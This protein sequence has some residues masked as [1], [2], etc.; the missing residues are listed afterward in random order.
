ME[1]IGYTTSDF[2]GRYRHCVEHADYD[3]ARA[4][5]DA[6]E[7]DEIGWVWEDGSVTFDGIPPEPQRG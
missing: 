2:D 4:R 7:A 1:C 5:V 3:E 6:G